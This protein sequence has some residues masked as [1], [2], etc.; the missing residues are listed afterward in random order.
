MNGNLSTRTSNSV[1]YNK[2]YVFSRRA[3]IFWTLFIGTGAL[4][5]SLCMLI[6]PTGKLLRM[7]GM[8]PYFQ[9]LPFAETLFHNYV[10]SGIA[11]LIVNGLT[12]FT[13]AFLLF[14][15]KKAGEILGGAF[16]VTLMLWI[17]IQFIIF[18]FNF[19]S[20]AYFICGALQSLT[21]AL[22][23]IGRAQSEFAAALKENIGKNS[24]VGKNG[25]KLVVYFSRKGYVEKI[26]YDLANGSG[27]DIFALSV[28]ERTEGN[29]G[30]WWCGRY[31]ML[32]RPMKISALPDHLGFYDKVTVCFPVWAFGICAPV[33]DFLIRAKGQ[34]R[35]V[36]YV[37]VHFM[38]ASFS[39]LVDEADSLIGL[40]RLS[41][42]SYR[43]R[44]GKIRNVTPASDETSAETSAETPAKE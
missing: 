33:R 34:V 24:R 43:C 26:A 3:L 44:F 8:L 38:N 13:A 9:V 11:L 4:W 40:K 31:A 30:F 12:N 15:R 7:D 28:N 41:F 14:R 17:V 25:K 23:C 35:A 20:T 10:F 22:C 2:R 1:V 37:A 39:A 42:Q 19:L 36:R 16:G 5:G 32:R 18:P 6:D 21:G 29:A 27:A